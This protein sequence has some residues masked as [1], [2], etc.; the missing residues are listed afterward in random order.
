[1]TQPTVADYAVPVPHSIRVDRTLADAHRLMRAHRIR[2]LPVL[3]GNRLVGLV[4]QRDLLFI[5]TL[6]GVDPEKVPVEEAMSQGPYVVGRDTPTL[7]R[8]LHPHQPRLSAPSTLDYARVAL[9]THRRRDFP[10]A[11]SPASKSCSSPSTTA[12]WRS[13]TSSWRRSPSTMPTM[14]WARFIRIR[15]R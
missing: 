3:D 8:G 11:R 15:S 7:T 13:E 10:R 5:E 9:A 1:M 4:S 2:H 14:V 12:A 6:Q